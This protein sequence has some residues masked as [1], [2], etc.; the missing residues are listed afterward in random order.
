MTVKRFQR[1]WGSLLPGA[2]LQ[3]ACLLVL[4]PAAHATQTHKAPEGLYVHQLGHLLFLVAMVLVWV[5]LYR[6]P[7]FAG[8]GWAYIKA[9]AV[10]FTLWNL[11]AF[12]AHWLEEMMPAEPFVGGGGAWS[13]I[14]VE[15]PATIGVPFYLTKFDHL[16]CVPGI[17]LF[18][19]GLRAFW[20]EHS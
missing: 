3:L 20:R 18:F 10:L 14:L 2:A 13:L 19:L 6:A 15:V 11:D 5:R 9:S 8:R 12:V 7:P 4:C 17:A 1:R 16:L